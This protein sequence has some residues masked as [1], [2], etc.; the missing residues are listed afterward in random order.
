M[1]I[2]TGFTEF[3]K[4]HDTLKEKI[5]PSRYFVVVDYATNTIWVVPYRSTERLHTYVIKLPHSE[6]IVE[7]AINYFIEL[8]FTVA[9]GSVVSE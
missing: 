2:Y 8:G 4:L 5:T 3:K 6:K 1:R 7:E 9:S